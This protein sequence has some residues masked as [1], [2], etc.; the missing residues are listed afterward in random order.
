MDKY[1]YIPFNYTDNTLKKIS[2][3]FKRVGSITVTISNKYS[4]PVHKHTKSNPHEGK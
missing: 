3:L 1:S 2:T 4:T